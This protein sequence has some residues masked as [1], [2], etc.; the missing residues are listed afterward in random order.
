MRCV[1]TMIPGWMSIEELAWLHY[2]AML[3]HS[4]VEVGCWQGRSTF[5]I[6]TGCR[7]DVY[8]VDT[9][10]GTPDELETNHAEAKTEDIYNLFMQNVGSF[11]NLSVLHMDSIKA[12]YK[13]TSTGKTV[14]MVFID[15]DHTI[16]AVLKDLL[17]WGP[18]CE[19][20]LC[21][22]DRDFPGVAGALNQSG[23]AWHEGPG[24]LWYAV[25]GKDF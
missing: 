24:S 6:L 21:G 8:A 16:E 19:R 23:I 3:S 2:Q 14:D 13:F 20:F 11:N 22:H 1:N 25:R 7:G 17:A 12:A 9:F 18:V 15:A 10:K 4:V 5:A